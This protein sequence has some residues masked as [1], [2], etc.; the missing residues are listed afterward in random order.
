MKL[1]ATATGI[2]V[3]ATRVVCALASDPD[4]LNRACARIDLSMFYQSE[5]VSLLLRGDG[6][7]MRGR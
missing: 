3:I 1:C 7:G 5:H 2:H 4:C 6:V